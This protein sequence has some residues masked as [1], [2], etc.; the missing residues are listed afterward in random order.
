[1]DIALADEFKLSETYLL[2][3]QTINPKL[4]I[5][6]K[7]HS[8]KYGFQPLLIFFRLV[9]GKTHVYWTI[10]IMKTV[11]K[12]FEAVT[13]LV[14]LRALHLS[15]TKG[16][17]YRG[18]WNCLRWSNGFFQGIWPP[19]DATIFNLC[20]FNA[21]NNI[22]QIAAVGFLWLCKCIGT[23]NNDVHLLNTEYKTTKRSMRLWMAKTK[24]R[25]KYYRIFYSAPFCVRSN[26]RYV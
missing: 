13:D 20:Q 7:N 15:G 24:V 6:C 19:L 25:L 4:P 8:G 21:Y 17:G 11:C 16:S 3:S 2:S 5:S 22:L 12:N 26:K 10:L 23:I 14:S 1:M 9:I 18:L